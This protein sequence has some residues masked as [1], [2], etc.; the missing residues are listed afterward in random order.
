[1][2]YIMGLRKIVGSLPL[3]MAG[4]CVILLDEQGRILLQRR[5]DNGLWGLP[6]GSLEP[7]EAMEDVARRELYEETGLTAGELK[8][9]DVF[10]G[11]GLHYTY[12]NGD[13]VHNVVCAYI[14]RDYT[15][16]LKAEQGEVWELRFFELLDIPHELSPPEIPVITKY[17]ELAKRQGK[18]EKADSRSGGKSAVSVRSIHRDEL[19]QL[20]QLYKHL[21]PGDPELVVD[22]NLTELLDG[23]LT[24]PTRKLLVAEQEGKLLST[25]VLHILQ[26]L[27]RNARPYALIE[28]VVTHADYRSQGLGQLILQQAV[29][30]ARQQRCYKVM[31]M[32]SSRLPAVHQ[33]YEQAGF[34]KDQKTAFLMKL[35]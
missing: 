10:S 14:C 5:V 15:G 12:P 9:L 34:R 3:I 4:A 17:L 30:I 26:N 7:G 25:C 33:F 32:T 21:Q 31:L 1:M 19:P 18:L 11:E 6:G 24:D 29:D 20:L 13:E 2:G 8:L 35:E 22:D 23:I 16:S 28:N 27:T